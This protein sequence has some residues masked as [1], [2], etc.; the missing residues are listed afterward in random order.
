MRPFGNPMMQGASPFKPSQLAGVV[1]WWDPT[2]TAKL[3]TSGSQ[4]TGWTDEVAGLLM[5]PQGASAA[6]IVT[7]T[8]G[9]V[10]AVSLPG[11]NAYLNNAAT[12]ASF[13]LD[14]ATQD[15][16]L[17]AVLKFNQALS[18]G[19]SP[20]ILGYGSGNFNFGVTGPSDTTNP[21]PGGPNMANNGANMYWTNSFASMDG[22][23]H[24]LD[25]RYGVSGVPQM[26]LDGTLGVAGGSSN[27]ASLTAASAIEM[28]RRFGQASEFLGG[29]IGDI[30]VGKN[31][32]AS[33]RQKIEGYLA[34][35]WG[36]VSLLPGGHPYK[37]APPLA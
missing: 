34:W 16:F 14:P 26:Y 22:V 13:P 33:D 18:G 15:G 35:K 28:G 9:G 23:S 10:R 31:L 21:A 29:V 30:I 7:T 3:T 2:N 37:T 24:I 36:L 27:P 6:S 32:S 4:V 5:T 17:F 20:A 12:P 19:F 8:L 25:G 11:A 1:A